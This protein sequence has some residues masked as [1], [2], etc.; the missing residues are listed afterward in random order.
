MPELPEVETVVRDLRPRLV[1]AAIARVTT[2]RE[3]LRRPWKKIWTSRVIGAKFEAIHRRGKW[4]IIDLDNDGR[5]LLHLGMTGQ[6]TVV[7]AATPLT[8]HLHLRFDLNP[9]NRQLRFRDPRRFGSADWFASESELNAFLDDRLGPEP[10]DLNPAAFRTELTRTNRSLK[11]LLL[12]QKVIAGVGNIYADETLYRLGLHPE[13]RASDVPRNLVEKLRAMI[14]TV[15]REA[16]EKRG[17]TIRDYIGGSGLEGG[18]Q[19][20]FRV[21]GRD[22]EPCL[23]CKTAIETVRVAGRTSHF[24]PSCQKRVVK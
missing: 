23:K 12:D 3:K 4:I 17:S 9:K 10:F 16:I 1:G 7:D 18:F 13:T 6:L 8:D 5:L 24:C 11:A 19:N 2:S 14:P 20:E 15:L 21:Y 22:G